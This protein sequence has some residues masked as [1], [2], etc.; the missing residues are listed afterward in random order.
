MDGRRRTLAAMQV[1][2]RSFVAQSAA[3]ALGAFACVAMMGATSASAC[4]GDCNLDSAVT[5]DEIVSLVN[6][7][8]AA[9]TDGC[10]A[11][12]VNGDGSITVEEIVA[13]LNHA[14][15]GCPVTTPRLEVGTAM[16]APGDSVTIAVRLTG[17][18]NAYYAA[19]LDLTYDATQVRVAGEGTPDCTIDPAIGPGSASNKRLLLAALPQPDDTEVLRVGVIGFTRVLPLPDGPLFTCRFDVAPLA[20]EGSVVLH[21]ES[22][23][24]D[25]SGETL[26]LDGEDGVIIVAMPD[27]SESY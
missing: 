18:G 11:G 24:A 27:A 2:R 14:L 12:D 26:R 25:E 10:A 15:N 21:A 6:L 7:A 23:G 8:L 16:G 22:E 20:R 9:G 17:G 5:V 19:S 3:A 13:A 4:S 1:R